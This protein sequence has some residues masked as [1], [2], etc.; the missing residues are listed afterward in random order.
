MIMFNLPNNPND[1]RKHDCHDHKHDHKHDHD[2]GHNP[3]WNDLGLRPFDRIA[4]F[5]PSFGTVFGI[6][7]RMEGN[8]VVWIG[9]FPGDLV[10]GATLNRTVLENGNVSKLA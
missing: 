3:R 5:S 6:F 8:V 9:D 7:L 4:V 1:N 2:H 10:P